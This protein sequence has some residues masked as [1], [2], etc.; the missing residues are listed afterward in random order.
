M[1]AKDQRLFIC[2]L[3]YLISLPSLAGTLLLD[4][5]WVS[6]HLNDNKLVLIDMADETQYQRFHLPGAIH[7]PFTALVAQQKNISVP[8]PQE[9]LIALLG[10]LGIS[11]DSHVVVYDDVG[12]LNAARLYWE[13][14]QLGHD[15]LSLLNGGLVKWILEGKPVTNRAPPAATTVSYMTTKNDRPR[16]ATLRDV[17]PASRSKD[18]VLLDVR[19]EEEYRGELREPRSG[20]IPGA[21]WFEWEQAVNFAD[22]FVQQDEKPLRDKLAQLGVNHAKQ[23]IITYCR[24]S[25]RAAQ[26]YFALRRLGFDNVKVY[27]G[28]MLEY[29][30]LKDQPLTRGMQP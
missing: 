9:R 1:P 24:S 19:S 3:L 13:L 28:S 22:G 11:R 6:T 8:I 7:L 12:G 15:K 23:P 20:H 30:Q 16:L 4:T 29:E 2:T 25:H 17:A 27:T 14:E 18:T 5:E 10:R 26:T 21:Q